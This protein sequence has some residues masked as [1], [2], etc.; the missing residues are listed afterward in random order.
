MN[1]DRKRKIILNLS[2]PPDC[3]LFFALL[4]PFSMKSEIKHF[5]HFQ[6]RFSIHYM[7]LLAR[8]ALSISARTSTTNILRQYNWTC[9]TVVSFENGLHLPPASCRQN[10]L[11]S[12]LWYPTRNDVEGSTPIMDGNCFV[13]IN[14]GLID[15]I[16]PF[17]SPWGGTTFSASWFNTICYHQ[18]LHYHQTCPCYRSLCSFINEKPDLAPLRNKPTLPAL[19]MIN[20][21]RSRREEESEKVQCTRLTRNHYHFWDLRIELFYSLR[22][23]SPSTR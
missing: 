5:I 11:S 21:S 6:F 22:V 17:F 4:A 12:M 14:S 20:H 1:D 16:H 3:N 18:W 2:P 13:F 23:P 7:S 9:T 8:A 10:F 19:Q 15:R